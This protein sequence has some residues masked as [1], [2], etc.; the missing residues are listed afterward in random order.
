[1]PYHLRVARPS[2]ELDITCQMYC[3]GLGL[4]VLAKFQDHAGFDGVILG[5]PDCDFHLEFTI[6]RQHPV[7]PTPT[8]EDILVFYVPA[9][10]WIDACDQMIVA[11]FEVVEASNPFWT[12]NG[13]CFQDTDGYYVVLNRGKW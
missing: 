11:G 7:T 9:E 6:S 2:R 3:A 4:Q 8:P 10:K 1:M 13:R 12:N 5:F